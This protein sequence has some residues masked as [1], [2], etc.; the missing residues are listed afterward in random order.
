MGAI[1]IW[2]S[3]ASRKILKECLTE[4]AKFYGPSAIIAV[5][6]GM[7]GV[8]LAFARV[9]ALKMTFHDVVIFAILCGLAMMM[10]DRLFVVTMHRQR[11]PNFSLDS[12]SSHLTA[13]HGN[14][15]TLMRHAGKAPCR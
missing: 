1:F 7:A 6:G 5:T 14:R 2:L 9:N 11:D 12:G 8:S 10:I 4:R 13:R 15:P 3:G